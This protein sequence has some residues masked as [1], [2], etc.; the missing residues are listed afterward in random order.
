[1]EFG[2]LDAK[3]QEETK[4]TQEKNEEKVIKT[5]SSKRIRERPGLGH[6]AGLEWVFP[7]THGPHEF[8]LATTGVPTPRSSPGHRPRPAEL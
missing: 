4:V 6:F 2:A 5:K 3:R 7:H 8:T 1:M